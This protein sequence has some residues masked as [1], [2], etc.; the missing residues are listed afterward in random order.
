MAAVE[1]KA[2]A[3]YATGLHQELDFGVGGQAVCL[4]IKLSARA[5]QRTV[6]IESDRRSWGD[7]PLEAAGVQGQQFANLVGRVLGHR[8]R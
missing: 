7:N 4:H 2:S 3:H 5:R 8:C 1:Q 6:L